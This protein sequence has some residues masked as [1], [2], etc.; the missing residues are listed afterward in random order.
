MPRYKL[1]IEYD[2][3]PYCGWQK[4]DNGPSVQEEIETA[5]TK[6]SGETARLYVA[7]RT[8]AGVHATGQVAHVDLEKDYPE[9]TV[10]KALNYH[11]N[12]I[13]YISI[14]ACEQVSGDFHARFSA[15]KRHYLYKIL[16]RQ[17]PSPIQDKR[18][19]H[20]KHPL[21]VAAMHKAAQNLLGLHDF[22]TFRS[23]QCQADSPVR[24]LDRIDIVREGDEIS[25]IIEAKSFLHH[26]VRNFVGTLKLVGEGKWSDQD[27][28]TALNAKDRTKGG[29]TAPAHGLYLVSVKY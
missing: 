6:F 27:L 5:V 7:G 11:L 15:T 2:G 26:Q 21:D 23:T 8:D 28:I 17:A 16:N 20:V 24:T 1:T 3:T 12:Q 19:L 14:V 10:A 22:S 18:A 25:F 13:P 29:P 4:Q 9:Q